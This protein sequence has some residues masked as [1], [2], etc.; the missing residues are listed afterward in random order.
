MEYWGF[1]KR[2]MIAT[3]DDE[4]L[5]AIA[6]VESDRSSLQNDA[7]IIK[8]HKLLIKLKRNKSSLS[9]LAP[10]GYEIGIITKMWAYLLSHFDGK[11]NNRTGSINMSSVCNKLKC[12]RY[13]SVA[14]IGGHIAYLSS[15]HKRLVTLGA[16]IDDYLTN[17][18][19]INRLPKPK[20]F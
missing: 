15:S 20:R 18:F 14:N 12:S 19:I 1:Y 17:R 6:Q 2:L 8:Y 4:K 3:F 7:E 5:D 9:D 11:Q 16:I 10:R 13:K